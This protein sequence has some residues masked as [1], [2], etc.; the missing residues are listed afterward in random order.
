MKIYQLLVL[1]GLSIIFNACDDKKQV[2]TIVYDANVYTVNDDFEMVTAFAIKDGRFVSIG[3]SEFILDHFK[4]V[5]YIDAGTRP[6]YPGFNDGHSHFLGYGLSQTI[7]AN[8]VGTK[9]FDEVIDRIKDHFGNNPSEWLLGRGWD[10]NDWPDKQFPTKEKLDKTFPETAVVLRRIDGHAL[11]ANSE[12]MRRANIVPESFVEGGEVISINGEPTGV[13]IDNAMDLVEAVIPGAT[14]DQKIKAL[15]VAEENCFEV[16]LTTVSDA[17]LH[18]AD[19][20]LMDA[21]HKDNSLKMRIYAM[22]SPTEEN[23]NY[24]FETG[25]YNSGRL[26]VS[27][28]KLYIDGALGSRGALLL[29]PYSDDPENIGLQLHPEVYYEEICQM[30]YD[31]GFQVNTHAIG[32]SGNRIMLRTYANQLMG[33]NDRRWRVEHAQIVNPDDLN[34][35]KD[36]NI[37]PSVQSTHCTSDMYWADERLGKERIKHAYAYQDLLYQNG[38]FVNGTDFPVEDI[39]P[40]KTFYAAVGR[41]DA[42]GWPEGGFQMENAISR[43]DALRSIT[44]WPAKGSFEESFKGSIEPGKAA[45]FVILD[46]DIMKI[47]E[48]NILDTKVFATYIGGVAVFKKD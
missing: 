3:E 39:S 36:Y 6:V 47:Q 48:Q 4:A 27:S 35:F 22:M 12:A 1:M 10:Q 23:F 40:I 5:K 25:P 34:Y 13:F 19:I 9:S 37:I 44:I 38:W 28:V 32:D 46:Q 11:I 16:G 24:F 18:K 17:G 26:S 45:D 15:K 7:S 14:K 29:E 33:E 8:L 31:A 20:L 2:D 42:E 43:E 41:K 21:M 30:A